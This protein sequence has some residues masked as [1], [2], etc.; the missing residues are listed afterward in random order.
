MSVAG[1]APP[2]F[3]RRGL[4]PVARLIFF[5]A[6]SLALLITDLRFRTLEW[7]RLAVATAAWPLQRVAYLPIDA[8][9]DVSNYFSRLSSLIGE[10]ERLR[11]QQ[12]NTANLLLRQK[13]LEDENRRLRVLMEMK[14]RHPVEG[15][16]AEILYAARDP[17][18][19]RVIIDKGAQQGIEAGQAVVDEI[20]VIGQVVR[21]FPLTSEVSLLTDKEQ[22]IP[23]QVQRN[24]LR[25]VLEGAGAGVME[26]RFL[27]TNAEVEIGDVLIT[28][29]LD[30]VYLPGLPVAKV[31][32]IDRSNSGS[33]SRI[34]CAPLAGVERRGLVLVMG[35]RTGLP[36]RPEEP[37]TDAKTKRSVTSIKAERRRR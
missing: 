23:I 30:G 2:P 27:A 3:F 16:I 6:L 24:G 4:A 25:A 18:A 29:G 37:E 35:S 33:F 12:L 13:H 11:Q 7:V 31:I 10:N 17:F 14:E 1:H 22:A 28:S 5:I 8:G 21:V 15:R 9:G 20:G 32:E 19:R 36:E 34:R 26:L